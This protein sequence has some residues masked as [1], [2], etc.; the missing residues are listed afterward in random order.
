MECYKLDGFFCHCS[1]RN[2]NDVGRS[3]DQGTI[4]AIDAI[5]ATEASHSATLNSVENSQTKNVAS[6]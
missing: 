3:I 4:D 6:R 1:K 2:K 5:V